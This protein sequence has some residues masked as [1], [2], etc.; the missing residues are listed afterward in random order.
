MPK[1]D[2]LRDVPNNLLEA[3][4]A[5]HELGLPIQLQDK[6][7]AAYLAVADWLKLPADSVQAQRDAITNQPTDANNSASSNAQNVGGQS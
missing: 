2:S 3:A 5:A 4:L 1:Q 6:I 7:W